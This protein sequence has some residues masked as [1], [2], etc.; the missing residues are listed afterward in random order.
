MLFVTLHGGKPGKHPHKNNVH[1][2]DKGGKEITPAVLEDVAGVILDELRRIY[3]FGKFLYV[4][5]ANRTQNSVL[6]FQGS[7]TKYKFAA[8]FLSPETSNGVLHPFDLAFDRSGHCYLSSQDTNLVTRFK[9]SP[10]GKSAEPA[11]IAPALAAL[12]QFLPGTFVA[13]SVGSLSKPPTTAVPPPAGLLFSGQGRKKHS[14][15]GIVWAG[16]ALYVADEPAGKIKVYDASG[17]FLGQSSQVESPV[18]L[19]VHAGKLYVSGSNQVFTAKLPKSPG[20]FLL[21]PIPGLRIKN[22][23]AMAFTKSGHFFIASR[24]EKYIRKFDARFKPMKFECTLPDDPEFL[25]HL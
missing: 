20:D 10:D 8:K 6:A 13:S 18:H 5:N 2:Y 16:N 11:P 19:V 4:V 22:G 17:E 25:L 12:G 3:R 21:S 14:V 9:I 7:D 1:A 24:T 15:R 23:G